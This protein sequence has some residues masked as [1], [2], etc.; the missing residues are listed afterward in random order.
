MTSHRHQRLL[1]HRLMSQDEPGL[2]VASRRVCLLPPCRIPT[3]P[4]E[5]AIVRERIVSMANVNACRP[6]TGCHVHG[7]GA[8]SSVPDSASPPCSSVS[9]RIG[10]SEAGNIGF[11]YRKCPAFHPL[12]L[13]SK[14]TR[15]LPSTFGTL[16]DV[17]ATHSSSTLL[18]I[19]TLSS[20]LDSTEQA[21]HR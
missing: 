18:A 16:N 1:H 4:L 14:D 10:F 21:K 3:Q 15:T 8:A 5:V 17:E 2:S 6:I 9:D 13:M 11:N 12:P 7:P 20:Q 19:C